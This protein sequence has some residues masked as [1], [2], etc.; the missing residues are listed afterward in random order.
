MNETL[1]KIQLLNERLEKP[2]GRLLSE[3]TGKRVQ[4]SRNEILDKMNSMANDPSRNGNVSIIYANDAKVYG[5]KRNWRTDDVSSALSRHSDSQDKEWYQKL[6]QYNDPSTKGKNPVAVV[7]TSRY[8]FHW[9]T[10]E[11][12]NKSVGDFNSR[13]S[14]LR[15]GLGYGTNREGYM[16]DNHNQRKHLDTGEQ[17]NQTGNLSI[18]VNMANSKKPKSRYYYVNADGTVD[19][20]NEMPSD[21]V[22]A[23]KAV[24]K[25]YEK[26]KEYMRYVEKEMLNHT[27]DEEKLK[28]YGEAMKELKNTVY[29]NRNL[30]WSK[31]LAICA[32]VDGQSFYYINDAVGLDFVDPAGLVKIAE[33]QL[34]ETFSEIDISEFSN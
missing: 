5:T 30:L 19:K 7:V 22:N 20:D 1:R 8:L 11:Q 14:E 15:M 10:T 21:I 13:R 32:T 27:Q 12:Y 18:D 16:G 26:G 4:V 29:D 28:A 25:S 23:M 6:T 33:D 31:I 2:Y 3:S 17:M 34:G 9:Q 24:P